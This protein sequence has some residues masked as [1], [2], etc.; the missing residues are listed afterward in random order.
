LVLAVRRLLQVA[1][2]SE[3]FADALAQA[4]DCLRILRPLRTIYKS[5]S[6]PTFPSRDLALAFIGLSAALDV[7]RKHLPS[8]GSSGASASQIV[9]LLDKLEKDHEAFLAAAAEVWPGLM[10]QTDPTLPPRNRSAIPQSADRADAHA[11]GPLRI[12]PGAFFYRNHRVALSGK[13]LCVLKALAKARGNVLTLVELRDHCWDGS[14][15]GEETIRSAVKFARAVLRQAIKESGVRC[16]PGHDPL[17]IV[18]RGMGQTAW[19][20]Q[21]P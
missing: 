9:E 6:G 20:L 1:T 19:R 13:P 17:P 2:G 12:E 4:L 21:L 10:A 14:I 8:V 7:F 11:S 5:A 16:Q 18:D 3:A 15:I